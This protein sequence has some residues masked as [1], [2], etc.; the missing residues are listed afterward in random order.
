[1]C[2]KWSLMWFDRKHSNNTI[3]FRILDTGDCTSCL[4]AVY[5]L[6]STRVCGQGVT[7]WFHSC[8]SS[9]IHFRNNSFWKKRFITICNIFFL[10][11][12]CLNDDLDCL[13]S[14]YSFWGNGDI[15]TCISNRGCS[16]HMLV[17]FDFH[18][19]RVSKMVSYAFKMVRGL[20]KS[21]SYSELWK[22][23]TKDPYYRNRSFQWQTTCT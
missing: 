23:K 18:T 4:S 6:S 17:P 5:V 1:M 19:S 12:R 16:S 14:S 2:F 9:F 22:E 15:Q 20:S 21:P 11:N 3:D 8:N 10:R 7:S 13:L